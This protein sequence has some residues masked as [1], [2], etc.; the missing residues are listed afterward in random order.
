MEYAIFLVIVAS[1]SLIIFVI[2]ENI[3]NEKVLMSSKK[4]TLLLE[5]NEKTV[6]HQ[7]DDCFVISKH[8]DNKS[9]FMKIQPAYIM[10]AEIKSNIAYFSDYISKVRENRKMQ[11]VYQEEIQQISFTK[12]SYDY[13]QLKLSERTY[14][15]H[16][17]KLFSKRILSP[18]INCEFIVNMSYSSP[19]GKV[20]LSKSGQFTFDDL[21]VCFESVSRSRIDKETYSNLIAVER[22]EISDSLRYDILNRDNFTCAICGASSKQGARLHVDHIIPVSKGGKSVPSNLRTLCERCN[23]GKSNKTET[24]S[25]Q[26]K[27]AENDYLTCEKCGAKLILREGKYGNFYGC[28]NYPRCKFTKNQ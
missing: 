17:E 27:K 6:F 18:I 15:R 9:N 10:T 7:I 19:K 21:F 4:I 23:I 26:S 8:Y 25:A 20:N 2:R 11:I 28:S 22:G 12:H 24:A 14:R 1:I 13:S 16:E 5:L 3:I